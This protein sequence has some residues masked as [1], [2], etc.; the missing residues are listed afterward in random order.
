MELDRLLKFMTDKGASDLHLKPTRPPLL[1]INGRLMPIEAPPLR[2]EELNEMLMG[3]L[4][5]RQKARLEERMSVDT[6]YGVRGLA[7]FRCNIYMQRGTIAASFRRIPFQIKGVDE[8]ELP[9]VLLDFCGL[10]MGLVLVTGPTGSGKSTTLAALIRYIS[11][12]RPCHVITIEDPMEFL[13]SDDM[14][15]IS[16]R[17]VGTDTYSFSEALRNAMRQDPDVIMVG[18]MRDPETVST[19]ITAAETGHL[20]FSTLHTNTAPQTIDRILDTFPA[21]QQAQVRAQL[22]QI[23]K[24]VVSMKLVER[25]DGEGR[26]A[27]LE[28]MRGSPKIAKMIEVGEISQIHEEIE[29]SVGYYRMQTM[30]Q[31][32]LALLVHGTI[33]YPEAMRQSPDPEDLS[34]KLRKMFP[35]I[36]ERGG[37]LSP[38]T[39][40]FSEIVELQQFKRLY[41]EQEEKTKLRLIEKDE[42]IAGMEQAIRQ[43]EDNL[44]ELKSRLQE[45][46]QERE[47]LRGDYNRLRQEAQEKIDKLMERIKELN[48]R[49]MGGDAAG[50]GQKSGIFR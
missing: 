23:L 41:E 16:Q 33:T 47:R 28:I 26:V 39:S 6:G 22:A 10:P 29:S 7:R 50:T 13:F 45:M 31:S 21:D 19:V 38:V 49:L 14:A 46:A 20:V 32:L 4:T 40:D 11:Q 36:E 8:L 18:E 27:A 35:S 2:M 1:R 43:R 48:Q 44:E 5:P 3:I 15:S 17:E 34:L 9:S 37:D 12:N 42:Q 30:N 25:Q 24:G